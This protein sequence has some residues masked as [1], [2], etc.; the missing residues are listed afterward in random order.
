VGAY[1]EII[2]TIFK[3]LDSEGRLHN[4]AVAFT[5]A[6]PE[7]DVSYVVQSFA[8]DLAANTHKRVLIVD[9]RAF[10]D[11]QATD[12]HQVVRQCAQ[13]DMDNV[14]ILSAVEGTGRGPS[15]TPKL[16]GWHSSPQ[17][18]QAYL[19]TLLWNFDYV[20]VDCPALSSSSDVKALAPILD[21]VAVVVEAKRRRVR[22]I[23]TS[24]HVVESFGGKFLGYI[25]NQRR[26]PI[27]TALG[28]TID[29]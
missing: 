21:G 5:S 9:A 12:V 3:A 11:L 16:T 26:Y 4:R 23:Q 7:A 22:R 14:M 20:I 15:I 27:L 28:L 25:L 24:Q 19:K 10:H 18:Q 8:K 29:D 13:T 2:S 17:I 6:L 1:S